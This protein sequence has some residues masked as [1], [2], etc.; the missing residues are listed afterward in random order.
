MAIAVNAH[1]TYELTLYARADE[2]PPD[3]RSVMLERCD[4]IL[5]ASWDM[6]LPVWAGR[7]SVFSRDFGIVLVLGDGEPVGFSIYRR[8]TVDRSRVLYRAGTNFL[9]AHH[10]HGLYSTLRDLVI[11]T[12]LCEPGLGTAPLVYYAWRTRNPIVWESNA[13]VCTALVPSLL[14]GGSEPRL[15]DVARRAAA[16]LHPQDALEVPSMIMRHAYRT[17]GLTYKAQPRHRDP[18]I[19]ALFAGNAE[20]ADPS[21]AIFSLGAL[22]LARFPVMAGIGNE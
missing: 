6:T 20:L 8:V 9:P 18:R 15:L 16:V 5:A 14:E 1:T 22:D 7:L 2:V 11:T 10:G 4:E 12:E 19:D 21:H 3:R 17:V 13:K